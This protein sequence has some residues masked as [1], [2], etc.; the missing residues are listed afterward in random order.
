MKKAQLFIFLISTILSCKSP[1][2]EPV[3]E[4]NETIQ[5]LD[6]T[7]FK[8]GIAKQDIQLLDVRTPKE[9][10]EGHIGDAILI[11]FL[12]DDFKDKIFRPNFT[13]KS[14]GMGLGLSICKQIIESAGGSISFES[15]L[16]IGTTFKVTLPAVK[17]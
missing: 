3:V 16:G 13:T 12:A 17:P 6:K 2:K 11:D 15:E 5:I 8:T 7:D 9:Y 14:S 1:V 4:A 10:E